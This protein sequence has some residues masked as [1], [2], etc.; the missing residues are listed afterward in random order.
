M[1]CPDEKTL[2]TSVTGCERSVDQHNCMILVIELDAAPGLPPDTGGI[3][4]DTACFSQQTM[5]LSPLDEK[6][7]AVP[8][9]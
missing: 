3:R 6:K 5:V 9:L 2:V 7:L 4:L 8:K 1:N